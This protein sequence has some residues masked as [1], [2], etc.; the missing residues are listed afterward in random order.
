MPM[1]FPDLKSVQ[2]LAT[3]MHKHE[4]DKQYKGIYPKTEKDL[5]EAR[6]Q[7][8]LYLRKV[9]ED[10]IF[11]IEVELGVSKE[12]YEEKISEGLGFR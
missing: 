12:N 10:K 8:G 6:R 1:Y 11:A 3:T 5:P 7:I 4:G 9:W 2:M